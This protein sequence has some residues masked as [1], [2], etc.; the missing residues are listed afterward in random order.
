MYGTGKMSES[1]VELR[2][3]GKL[4]KVAEMV[5]MGESLYLCPVVEYLG[6][7]HCPEPEW[8]WM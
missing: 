3:C 4:G 7:D 2:S 8:G 1:H 5:D 6:S